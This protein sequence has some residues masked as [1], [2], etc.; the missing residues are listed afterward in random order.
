MH[1]SVSQVYLTVNLQ[2]EMHVYVSNNVFVCV[3][4]CSMFISKKA[5]SGFRQGVMI[6]VCA[7]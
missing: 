6:V 2:N 7:G 5:F 3:Y 1:L 4:L